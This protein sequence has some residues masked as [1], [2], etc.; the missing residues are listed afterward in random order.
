[1]PG[2]R[3]G[4]HH[5][6]EAGREGAGA[7]ESGAVGH[8]VRVGRPAALAGTLDLARALR[9]LRQSGAAPGPAVLDE[10]ATAQATAE[11]GR[12]IP[13][14]RPALERRFSVDLVIDTGATMA[15]WHRLAAEL[16]TLLERHGA[17][18]DVRCWSLGT[19]GPRPRLTRF[20]RGP[21]AGLPAPAL[22][23]PGPLEDPTG[24]AI[25]LVLT[26]GVGPA[27]YGDALPDFLAR[28]T[29]RRPAAALQV[30]PRRLWHRTA[31]RTAP[32]ELRVQ[33]P[34]S[35]VAEVRTTAA[36]PHAGAARWLPVLEVDGAWLG[37]WAELLAGRAGGW[38]PMLAA[39]V[40]GVPRPRRT[41]ASAPPPGPAARV[42]RFRAG[43]SPA[44]FRLACHLAAAPLSLPVMR[45]V[46]RADSQLAATEAE[47]SAAGHAAR[48]MADLLLAG[49]GEDRPGPGN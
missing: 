36:L 2:P 18:A 24:R 5:P 23:W 11:A 25:L 41:P 26:D 4:L 12:L 31:L 42:A 6:A 39:P 16:C 8:T 21:G 3:V 38:S 13:V 14:W 45:L 17:F 46:L 30:L 15:V 49:V 7:A 28:V 32:V 1:M 20:R 19:D 29:A 47:R 34:A 9:P 44:A 48:R 22:P 40:G 43:C 10:E 37:P 27:W 35:P 33:D